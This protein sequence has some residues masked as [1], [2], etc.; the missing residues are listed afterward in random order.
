[1]RIKDIKFIDNRCRGLGYGATFINLNYCR[2]RF[3]NSL[4]FDNAEGKNNCI[5]E[6]IA[7]IKV[8]KDLNIVNP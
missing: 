4:I 2:D 6:N 3:K 7:R 5:A 8:D 1:M